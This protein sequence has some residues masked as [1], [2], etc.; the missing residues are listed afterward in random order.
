MLGQVG[1]EVACG[2]LPLG[3]FGAIFDRKPFYAGLPRIP[4]LGKGGV[5]RLGHTPPTPELNDKIDIIILIE[6]GRVEFPDTRPGGGLASGMEKDMVTAQ[7][8]EN[9]NG[10]MSEEDTLASQRC[11]HPM[12][13]I[14]EAAEPSYRDQVK[15]EEVGFR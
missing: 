2:R 6:D 9:G 4:P 10:R 5:S 15:V 3:L 1:Q 8:S 13:S 12:R 11:G 7:W 14:R